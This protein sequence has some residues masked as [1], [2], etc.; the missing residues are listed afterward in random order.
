MSGFLDTSIIV[1]YITADVPELADRA[2]DIIEATGPLYVTPVVLVEAAFVLTRNYEMP[3]EE[4]V[5]TLIEL[6]RRDNVQ[7]IDL[8]KEM[9][10]EA[11]LHCRPSGRVSFADAMI[12]AAARSSDETRTI[13][14][15]DRRFPSEGVELRDAPPP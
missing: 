8:E 7:V 5:D 6:I 9:V 14:T 1:R 10:V 12:W 11:L 4:V 3:R 13:Y 2:A 15:F